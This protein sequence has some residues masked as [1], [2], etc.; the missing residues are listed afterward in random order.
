VFVL[1]ILALMFLFSIN[2]R[3]N[4]DSYVGYIHIKELNAVAKKDLDSCI[5]LVCK[6]YYL[7]IGVQVA[8]APHGIQM[9]FQKELGLQEF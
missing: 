2:W 6:P 8:A 3:K 1:S 4:E 7:L 5:L 9:R